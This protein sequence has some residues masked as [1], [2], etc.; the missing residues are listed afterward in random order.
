[1]SRLWKPLVPQGATAQL[2]GDTIPALFW[3]GV[4]ARGPRVFLREKQFGIWQ[5]WTWTQVGDAVRELGLGQH[6][7]RG[8]RR[9]KRK[10]S[11]Q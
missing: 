6:S 7:A 1:M 8:E 5:S 10:K 4:A 3:A 2:P 9:W 11:W